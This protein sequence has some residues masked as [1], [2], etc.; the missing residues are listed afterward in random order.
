MVVRIVTIL[1][2]YP[3]ELIRIS[4]G[5]FKG[6]GQHGIASSTGSHADPTAQPNFGCIAQ[7]ENCSYSSNFSTLSIAFCQEIGTEDWSQFCAHIRDCTILGESELQNRFRIHHSVL[8][9]DLEATVESGTTNTSRANQYNYQ[10]LTKLYS[11]QFKISN[12]SSFLPSRLSIKNF[13]VILTPDRLSPVQKALVLRVCRS[14][15]SSST[16]ILDA[17]PHPHFV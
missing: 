16:A 5:S 7:Y 13:S 14:S 12:L 6:W 8:N 4:V 9:A 17:S 3:I 11:H 15:S 10:Y 1:Q 2:S